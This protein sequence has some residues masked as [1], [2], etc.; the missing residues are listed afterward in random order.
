[1][2]EGFLTYLESGEV[3]QWLKNN[4]E[5]LMQKM[6]TNIHFEVRE[7]EGMRKRG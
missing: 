3:P 7:A 4:Y 5:K 1:L 2:F 6:E